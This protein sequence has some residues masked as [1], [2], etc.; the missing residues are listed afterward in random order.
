MIPRKQATAAET[1][2]GITS[3]SRAQIFRERA[4]SLREMAALMAWPDIRKDLANIA[5]QYELVAESIEP[6]EKKRPGQKPRG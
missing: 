2:G 5:L 3:P 1:S 4:K 6:V